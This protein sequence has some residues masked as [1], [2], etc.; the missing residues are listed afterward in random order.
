LADGLNEADRVFAHPAVSGGSYHK[1]KGKEFEEWRR[2]LHAGTMHLK[3][4]R[5]EGGRQDLAFD[6]AL[7]LFVNRVIFLE[8]LRE[9]VFV[10][11]HQNILEDYLWIVLR[12][13]EMTALRPCRFYPPPLLP[14]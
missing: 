9:L 1:G 12:S 7:P 3:L 10:P 4:E 5:A 14:A 2:K 11:D 8:F 6:G 13:N